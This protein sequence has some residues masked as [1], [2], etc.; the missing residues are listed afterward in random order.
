MRNRSGAVHGVYKEKYNNQVMQLVC[1]LYA[2]YATSAGPN[3]NK[4]W[5]RLIAMQDARG[6]KNV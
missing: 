4:A 5:V 2:T 3:T 6:S 1:N